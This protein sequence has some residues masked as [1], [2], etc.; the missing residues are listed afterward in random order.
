MKRIAIGVAVAIVILLGVIATRPDHYRVERAITV[1]TDAKIPYAIVSD[2]HNG[3][4]WSPWEHLDPAMKKEYFGVVSGQGAGYHWAGNKDAGEGNMT[5]TEAVAPSHLGMRLEFIKPFAGVCSTSY[6]FT[7]VA[8]GTSITWR[9]EGK[10]D[11]MGKAVSL[12]CN[13]DTM[14]GKDFEKGLA[15]LKTLVE[16]PG[17]AG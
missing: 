14:I 13:M 7:P 8:G 5:I 10:N 3:A 6:D 16:K 1:A 2:H 17:S 12:F 15:S 9:M 11:F 4:K